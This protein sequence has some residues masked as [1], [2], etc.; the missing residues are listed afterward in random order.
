[1]SHGRR[2]LEAQAQKARTSTTRE[3]GRVDDGHLRNASRALNDDGTP[4]RPS[5]NSGAAATAARRSVEEEGSGDGVAP[6][7]RSS[8]EDDHGRQG[9]VLASPLPRPGVQLGQE[10]DSSRKRWSRQRTPRILSTPQISL[11]HL[12]KPPSTNSRLNGSGCRKVQEKE[13]RDNQQQRGV[14]RHVS[15]SDDSHSDND[16]TE[17]L[18]HAKSNRER[19]DEDEQQP[20]PQCWGGKQRRSLSAS[21]GSAFRYP[22]DRIRLQGPTTA[23]PPRLPTCAVPDSVDSTSVPT[24]PVT[25]VPLPATANDS[26]T[27][28]P[29]SLSASAAPAKEKGLAGHQSEE[30]SRSA[31]RSPPPVTL[32]SASLVGLRA[33]APQQQRPITAA[34][35]PPVVPP[36]HSTATAASTSSISG[37]GRHDGGT[38]RPPPLVPPG[39]GASTFASTSSSSPT[40]AGAVALPHPVNT[41]AGKTAAAPSSP[42]LLLLTSP[43]SPPLRAGVSPR[44]LPRHPTRFDP[45]TN[46]VAA[47][48]SASR[49]TSA[50]SNA[51]TLS[52]PSMYDASQQQQARA[53]GSPTSAAQQGGCEN[54]YLPSRQEDEREEEKEGGVR[55]R[56]RSSASVKAAVENTADQLMP[57]LGED[58]W[59]S[60]PL[61]PL[62]PTQPSED[63]PSAPRSP[64]A[65][66]PADTTHTLLPPPSPP[67]SPPPPPPVVS[68][69]TSISAPAAPAASPPSY[70]RP[71]LMRNG[72]G[73]THYPYLRDFSGFH[74][75]GNDCYGCSALTML[76]RST[77]FRRALLNSPLVVAARRYDSLCFGRPE[78]AARW[79][80]GYVEA[81]LSVSAKKARKRLRTAQEAEE[82]RTVAEAC[83]LSAVRSAPASSGAFLSQSSAPHTP[84]ERAVAAAAG[85]TRAVQRTLDFVETLSFEELEEVLHGRR[86]ADRRPAT[87]HCALAALALAVRWRELMTTQV[88]APTLRPAERQRLLESKIYHDNDHLFDGQV[89][90]NGI[91]LSAVAEL[92]RG[93]FFLGEQED[94]HELFVALMAKL[95]SE[96]VDFQKCCAELFEARQRVAAAAAAAACTRDSAEEEEEAEKEEGAGEEQHK[97]RSMPTPATTAEAASASSLVLTDVPPPPPPRISTAMSDA[98]INAL[99]QTRLLNI[100]RCCR[101]GCQHEIVTDEI[102]VNLS[103]HIP[104]EVEEAEEEAGAGSAVRR[105]PVT[106]T[107]HQELPNTKEEEE[108]GEGEEDNDDFSYFPCLASPTT[109][110][111]SPPQPTPAAVRPSS[112]CSVAALLHD[113]MAFEPLSDYRCDACGSTSAQY[114]GGCFYTHPPPVLVL[115]LKR[116]STEFVKGSLRIRKNGRRVAVEDVLVVYALPS[117]EE[118]RELHQQQQ[119]EQDRP[120]LRTVTLAEVEAEA[121]GGT[122]S[123]SEGTQNAAAAA[124]ATTTAATAAAAAAQERCFFYSPVEKRF[125]TVSQE[126]D[127][128]AAATESD[129]PPS[130]SEVWVTAIRSVYRLQSCVL[131]LGQ[132]LHFGHYV[133]DFAV[134]GESGSTW[135]REGDTDNEN[136]D[137][138]NNGGT[139]AEGEDVRAEAKH[140]QVQ[141]PCN[142]THPPSTSDVLS[143][144]LS[145]RWRRANDSHVEVLSEEAVQSRR[146][147]GSDMYLLLYEKVEEEWARCPVD[148]VLPK[149]VYPAE[150]SDNDATPA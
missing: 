141:P 41:G 81:P 7:G 127:S 1:M 126:Q 37:A 89:Y 137:N 147:G 12:R 10:G 14:A 121:Q 110:P 95:E 134:V 108:E 57:V 18:L 104:D 111:P 94:A 8:N 49:A 76:L 138:N 91:R 9:A 101:P 40:F 63:I 120:P 56:P 107:Q 3:D 30:R 64:L 142:Q 67:P 48:F 116:F 109:S 70:V 125:I 52:Q 150:D 39:P 4:V 80:S 83:G 58:G 145:C 20:Q 61:S 6:E 22:A 143:S 25:A 65:A 123:P 69:D 15:V 132:S 2:M 45:T 98:W 55:K 114:Q 72:T 90:T 103:L 28:S 77:V 99:V 102:C 66:F 96:A 93:E 112:R 73:V 97:R 36:P 146:A 47:S 33:G 54:H 106:N 17:E 85:P 139:P 135:Q 16:A 115:Q 144:C 105:A 74:N 75:A 53:T 131:H 46:A 130:S 118:L 42:S 113:S 32:A 19:G 78:R 140:D 21:R 26:V 124:A 92:F 60:L 43:A 79:T 35:Q 5:R 117:T 86:G 59:Y 133:S 24:T 13:Q 71:P 84:G 38:L 23:P 88:N 27:S 29:M 62:P 31:S 11:G 129:S 68:C 82:N 148:A 119:Q 149:P 100:I 136:N 122:W 50:A 34:L 51:V 128:V 87:L 44:M